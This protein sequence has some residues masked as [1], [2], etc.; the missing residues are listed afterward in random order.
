MQIKDLFKLIIKVFGLYLL[1]LIPF[2]NMLPWLT[3]NYLSEKTATI[4]TGLIAL[5]GVMILL[6]IMIYNAEAVIRWFRLDQGFEQDEIK[7]NGWDYDRA[8][9]VLVIL[10]GGLIMV[11]AI[12]NFFAYSAIEFH[13]LVTLKD[14]QVLGSSYYLSNR[15][16]LIV[17]ILELITGFLIITNSKWV[18]KI[19][20]K[21]SMENEHSAE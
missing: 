12:P 7:L 4:F 16:Q 11:R 20:R 3:L 1:I 2:K 19:I 8:M 9:R 10:I 15:M 18:C 5:A 14:G 17:S 13:D 6:A 21:E